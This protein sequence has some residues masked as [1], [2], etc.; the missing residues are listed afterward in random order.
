MLVL[1]ALPLMSSLSSHVCPSLRHGTRVEVIAL[2]GSSSFKQCI[3]PGKL[4]SPF[5]LDVFGNSLE[6][7]RTEAFIPI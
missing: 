3:Y 4:W 5:R 6:R 1:P 2:T 7:T